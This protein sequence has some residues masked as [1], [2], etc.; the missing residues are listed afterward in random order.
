MVFMRLFRNWK[1]KR[2]ARL[3]RDVL[4]AQSAIRVERRRESAARGAPDLY[5][6]LGRLPRE[7]GRAAL[8]LEAGNAASALDELGGECLL[9]LRALREE[10][11]DRKDAPL[12]GLALES[13]LMAPEPPSTESQTR[14]RP[15]ASKVATPF[16]FL[17]VPGKPGFL[18][19]PDDEG[20]FQ[21]YRAVE[22]RPLLHNDST[23]EAER[24][25]L[26]SRRSELVSHLTHLEPGLW[27]VKEGTDSPETLGVTRVAE[28]LLARA[29]H[30]M[31]LL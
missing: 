21:L 7:G 16:L 30:E 23:G 8:G 17:R 9:I 18:V 5:A 3:A 2:N 13:G 24:P 19:E 25:S 15:P 29:V 10:Y 14:P 11:I 4:A 27:R 26:F 22:A 12:R 28:R 6:E 20:T 31:T 1:G